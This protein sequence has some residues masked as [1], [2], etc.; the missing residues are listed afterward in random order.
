MPED[1]SVVGFDGV[2]LGEYYIPRLAS[3]SQNVDALA[4]RSF[5]MLLHHIEDHTAAHYEILPVR[6]LDRESARKIN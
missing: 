5:S 6:L 4:A 1:V 3:I 2:E